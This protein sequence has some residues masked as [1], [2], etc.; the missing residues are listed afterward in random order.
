[1]QDAPTSVLGRVERPTNGA[2]KKSTVV[3]LTD[4]FK[5]L[6]VK[7]TYLWHIDVT[8]IGEVNMLIILS[9]FTHN[10]A[11]FLSEMISNQRKPSESNSET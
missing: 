11:Y 9:S 2:Q 6:T 8:P 4:V 1:M 5:Q 7:W 3:A 10:F